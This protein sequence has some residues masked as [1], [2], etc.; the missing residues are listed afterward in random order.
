MQNFDHVED[1]L[2]RSVLQGDLSEDAMCYAITET[3]DAAL[4]D[5]HNED[6][7]FCVSEQRLA[8]AQDAVDWW[9]DEGNAFKCLECLRLCWSV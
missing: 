4:A 6:V 3:L 1:K 8:L 9:N 5:Q 2:I 7:P